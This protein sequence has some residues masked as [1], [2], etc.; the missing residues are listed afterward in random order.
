MSTGSSRA[1]E[2]GWAEHRARLE[3]DLSSLWIRPEYDFL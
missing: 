1:N 3:L 2:V